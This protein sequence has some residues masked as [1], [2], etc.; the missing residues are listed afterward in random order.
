MLFKR[1]ER[2]GALNFL[3]S[4]QE[5]IRALIFHILLNF[6]VKSLLEEPIGVAFMCHIVFPYIR[7]DHCFLF[8]VFSCFKRSRS[9][10]V[11]CDV[12]QNMIVSLYGKFLILLFGPG[13]RYG[14]SLRKQIKKMEVSQHSRYFCEF[15]GKVLCNFS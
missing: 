5:L 10:F 11:N 8:L 1:K 12:L 9:L 13:T 2:E 7:V 4:C 15:C 6:R 3:K 14:A